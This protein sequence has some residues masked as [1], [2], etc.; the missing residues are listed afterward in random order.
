[1]KKECTCPKGV[2]TQ[3]YEDIARHLLTAGR[4][5]YVDLYNNQFAHM[6]EEKVMKFP[7]VL[8]EFEQI[9]W[10][11]LGKH[12]QRASV[13]INLHV[14]V[15]AAGRTSAA[16]RTSP[17]ALE[18]FELLDDIHRLM[19]DLQLGYAGTFTRT[20]SLTD[21]DHDDLIVCVEQYRVNVLDK[22]VSP[23]TE[24]VPATIEIRNRTIL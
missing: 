3:L 21:H 14:G 7:C 4:V 15:K 19:R 6:P 17:P 22:S 2:R 9:Q 18:Y 23:P 5:K 13:L 1:M 11:Q 12:C 24:R 8:V 10:Q 20:Q 16:E